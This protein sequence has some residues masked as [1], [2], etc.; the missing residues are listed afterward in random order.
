MTALLWK[1]FRENVYKVAT[2]LGVA[3]HYFLNLEPPMSSIDIVGGFGS[4]SDMV[5]ERSYLA[6]RWRGGWGWC[7]L[8]ARKRS[9]LTRAPAMTM[10]A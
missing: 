2:G 10:I 4:R 6:R 5:E 3:A 7:W 9:S 8:L 1:E